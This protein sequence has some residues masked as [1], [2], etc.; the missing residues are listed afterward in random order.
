MAFY[1][2]ETGVNL[3]ATGRN[4]EKRKKIIVSPGRYYK[5]DEGFV[6]V[7]RC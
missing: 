7:C 1:F 4:I 6:C 5:F 3:R 2:R